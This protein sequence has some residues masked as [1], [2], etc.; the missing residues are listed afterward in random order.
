MESALVDQ[1]RD[2]PTVEVIQT[3]SGQ[4]ETVFGKIVNGWRELKLSIE[5]GFDRMLIGRRDIEQVSGQQGANVTGNHLLGERVAARA[6]KHPS[7]IQKNQ[8]EHD[9]DRCRQG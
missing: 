4:T 7:L 3:S 8:P 1:C 2:L 5:P 6:I 9:G